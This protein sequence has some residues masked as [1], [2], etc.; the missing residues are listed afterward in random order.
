MMN[1]STKLMRLA[2]LIDAENSS[3]QIAEGL[4]NKIARMGEASVRRIY[5]D[6]SEGR[7]KGWIQK[8]PQHAIIAHQQFAPT[9]GKNTTD[10][11]LAIDAMDL[12]HREQLEGFCI[13]SSDGD[14]TPLAARLRQAGM[15][16]VGFGKKNT[17]ESFRQVCNQFVCIEGLVQKRVTKSAPSPA[18]KS[19][20]APVATVS[21]PAVP[22]TKPPS[23]AVPLLRTAMKS[24]KPDKDGWF[25]LG[26]VGHTLNKLYPDFDSRT[27]GSAK[28]S[29]L[30]QRTGQFEISTTQGSARIREKV[31]ANVAR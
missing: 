16:V 13:V 31:R 11:A 24:M 12:L 6:F 10:I 3:P 21:T 17:P 30:A 22:A 15:H 20:P 14:F 26:T 25:Y 9:S 7:L 8:L 27:F 23:A 19:P 4:F 5:G 18:S 2:V 1:E 28:F 29:K